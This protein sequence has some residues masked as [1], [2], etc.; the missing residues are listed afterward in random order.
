MEKE[1]VFTSTGVKLLW[2]GEVIEQLL[3]Y[4]TASPITLQVAPTSRCSLNCSFC[5]NRNRQ[6]HED[7]DVLDLYVVVHEL[8]NKGLK[9]IEWTGGG[10]PTLYKEIN[11]CIRFSERLHLDQ[12]LITN[13]ILLNENIEKKSLDFLK[14]VRISM[15]CLDYVDSISIP[16]L[17]SATLGFS[18]VMNDNTNSDVLE[19]LNDHVLHYRPAYVR[20]VPNCQATDKEQEENNRKYKELVRSWGNPYFY[21][22]KVFEQPKECF[23]GYFK[24]FLL[25]DGYVYPCSSVVLNLGSEERFHEKYR[26]C[27]MKELVK[28]YDEE[29]S[30][31]AT[32][33]CNHCVFTKQNNMVTQ[34][35]TPTGMENFI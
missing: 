6:K 3:L 25:H 4:K 32:T 16:Y 24:P 11:E 23:W 13:G 7:L 8:K 29:I 35:L 34:L 33:N 9:A 18:Y 1:N 26:W 30:P 17:N 27:R 12:G 31:F 10:D 14:W 5:S 19:R 15:N 28:K 20:I 22:E 2:H 21:Q